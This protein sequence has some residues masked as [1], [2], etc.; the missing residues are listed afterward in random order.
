MKGIVGSSTRLQYVQL[1]RTYKSHVHFHHAH[2]VI[3]AI[4]NKTH[5]YGKQTTREI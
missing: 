3:Q 1:N 4:V 2:L 5:G